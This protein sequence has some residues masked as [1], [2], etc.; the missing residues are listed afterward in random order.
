MRKLAIDLV[1][2]VNLVPLPEGLIFQVNWGTKSISEVAMITSD[3]LTRDRSESVSRATSCTRSARDKAHATLRPA[4]R[5]NSLALS[6]ALYRRSHTVTRHV[7]K[8]KRCVKT[9][10]AA[11][12]SARLACLD[13][14]GPQRLGNGNRLVIGMCVF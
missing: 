12:L 2:Q 9:A 3:R 5:L 4:R 10:A 7:Q 11:S 8:F 1:S 6:A 14:P 13:G